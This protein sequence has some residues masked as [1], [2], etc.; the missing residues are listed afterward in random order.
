[1]PPGKPRTFAE[2]SASTVAHP[3][4]VAV[5]ALPRARGVR[6][7]SALRVTIDGV[8]VESLAR[9]RHVAGRVLMATVGGVTVCLVAGWPYWGAHVATAFI[10]ALSV[11]SI[12]LVGGL[13]AATDHHRTSGDLLICSA[14]MMAMSW[15]FVRNSGI[16]PLL[17]EVSNTIC[18]VFLAGAVMVHIGGGRLRRAS[19]FWLWLSTGVLAWCQFAVITTTEISERGYGPTVSW[20][21]VDMSA[22]AR[23]LL[24]GSTLVGYLVLFIVSHVVIFVMRRDMTRVERSMTVPWMVIWT[25]CIVA[26][27]VLESNVLSSGYAFDA[28]VA[29]RTKQ[30]AV[31]P[32]VPLVLMVTASRSVRQRFVLTWDLSRRGSDITH[33]ELQHA[34]AEGLKDDRLRVWLWSDAAQRYVGA[35]GD[36]RR[37]DSS[38]LTGPRSWVEIAAPAGGRMAAWEVDSMLARSPG[39]IRSAAETSAATTAALLAQTEAVESV[40]TLQERLLAAEH[41]AST[42]IVRD[43][44][45]GVQQ[46]LLSLTYELKR[47][48]RRATLAETQAAL[49]DCEERTRQITEEIRRLAR[50][51]QSPTLREMGL[52]AAVEEMAERATCAVAVN[53]PDDRFDPRLETVLYFFY[54]EALA[55]AQKHANPGMVEIGLRAN[56]DE[57]IGWVHDDGD[58]GARPEPGGGLSGLHDRLTAMRGSL[59]IDSR[60]G[61]GTQLTVRVP[62]ER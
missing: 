33:G 17:G 36:V 44:H 7:P 16:A 20:P 12:A 39:L 28:W 2:P 55:N 23:S 31:L 27:I 61:A 30:G 48:Q 22:Q 51:I 60:P 4:V 59:S 53:V 58:G 8:D 62:T 25:T 15:V 5:T 6:V 18:N 37:A 19:R 13:L 9:T 52:A 24:Q 29:T 45:D 46:L 49:V 40:R 10:A 41:E 43:L 42:R 50:G 34:L 26:G 47:G 38:V 57:V 21:Q 32:I 35:E 11:V 54:A 1:M 3:R 14:L 56:A